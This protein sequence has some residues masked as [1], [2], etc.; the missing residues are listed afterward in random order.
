MTVILNY[1]GDCGSNG[2]PLS[3]EVNFK[4][5]AFF[6]GFEV[7]GSILHQRWKILFNRMEEDRKLWKDVC[8][9]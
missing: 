5:R 3:K 7:L 2:V 4:L 1:E 6:N 8:R 9:P